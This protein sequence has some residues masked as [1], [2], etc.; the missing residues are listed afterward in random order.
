MDVMQTL[1]EMFAISTHATKMLL[2]TP[3]QSLSYDFDK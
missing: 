1:I 3:G 2:L